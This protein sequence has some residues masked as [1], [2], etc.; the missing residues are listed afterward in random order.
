MYPSQSALRYRVYTYSQRKHEIL[1]LYKH[2][3]YEMIG[4]EKNEIKK[5]LIRKRI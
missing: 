1:M 3:L 4:M 5:H 2:D